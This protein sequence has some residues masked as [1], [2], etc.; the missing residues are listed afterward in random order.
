MRH[1]SPEVKARAVETPVEDLMRPYVG[2]K[3][4]YLILLTAAKI[5]DFLSRGWNRAIRLA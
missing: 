5:A 1:V 2:P 3:T 4:N